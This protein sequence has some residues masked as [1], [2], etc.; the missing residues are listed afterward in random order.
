[1]V[2]DDLGKSLQLRG[3]L[4]LIKRGDRLPFQVSFAAP[5]AP[6]LAFAH[7]PAAASDQEVVSMH[8]QH[9]CGC[10]AEHVIRSPPQETF[11]PAPMAEGAHD[12]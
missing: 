6:R 1:M 5:L 11:L 8:H 9:R 2:R 10:L 7:G 12:Q 3:S 4:A